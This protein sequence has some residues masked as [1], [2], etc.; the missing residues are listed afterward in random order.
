MRRLRLS[1]FDRVCDFA[2]G[3]KAP[4]ILNAGVPF[5]FLLPESVN[6]LTCPV[7]VLTGPV[8]ILTGPVNTIDLIGQNF[9]RSGQNFDR[10]G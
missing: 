6:I 2:S 1:I 3:S 5:F 7:K 10:I 8:K 4:L 9:D